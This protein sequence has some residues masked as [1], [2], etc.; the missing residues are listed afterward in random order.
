MKNTT[1][2][3]G[4]GTPPLPPKT[5]FHFRSVE[6]IQNLFLGVNIFGGSKI[7]EVENFGVKNSVLNPQV[8][9]HNISTKIVCFGIVT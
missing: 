6:K 2:K 1:T 4:R 5:Q 8:E 3:I 7:V 9:C